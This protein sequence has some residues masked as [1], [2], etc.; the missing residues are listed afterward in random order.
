MEV[1]GLDGTL[2]SP[3]RDIRYAYQSAIKAVGIH[4]DSRMWEDLMAYAMGEGLSYDDLVDAMDALIRFLNS[5]VDD[6]QENMH[7]V[8]QRSGWLDQSAAAQIAMMAML[9]RVVLGQYFDALRSTTTAGERPEG[10]DAVIQEM[11]SALDTS[12]SPG[13]IKRFL[14][15]LESF[16]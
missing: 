11:A 13:A 14:R 8:L 12:K 3:T 1:R 7:D 2:F 10:L 6:S 5:S 4:F 15:W 9:G 16:F